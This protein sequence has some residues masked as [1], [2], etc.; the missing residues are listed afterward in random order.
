MIEPQKK[1]FLERLRDD[2]TATKRK[3]R[4][5]GET[6]VPTFFP[7]SHA[8]FGQALTKKTHSGDMILV[9]CLKQLHIGTNN[10]AT[11]MLQKGASPFNT[12][13]D[14]MQGRGGSLVVGRVGL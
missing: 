8:S 10:D 12:Y 9:N 1:V 4:L 6:K 5:Q 2:T 3:K 7:I 14:P 11:R 13:L